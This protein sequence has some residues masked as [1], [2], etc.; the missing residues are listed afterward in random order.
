MTPRTP[1]SLQIAIA[2]LAWLSACRA[3]PITAL[4]DVALVCELATQFRDEWLAE[5]AP[6]ETPVLERGEIVSVQ[7]S[8]PAW[9]RIWHVT[10]V[11]ET[12]HDQPE[13]LHDY[14]LHVHVLFEHSRSRCLRVE[15]GPDV[16]S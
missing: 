2:F 12:G 3:I 5:N 11:T 14:Y 7:R 10:F 15:R 6:A 8:G 16:I 4:P 13:G 1:W 9:R